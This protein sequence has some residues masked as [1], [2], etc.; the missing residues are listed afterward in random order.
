MTGD[1]LYIILYGGGWE[2]V[3]DRIG[4]IES[5]GCGAFLCFCKDHKL[6][7]HFG[8]SFSAD[9]S[10]LLESLDWPVFNHTGHTRDSWT[11][12]DGSLLSKQSLFRARRMLWVCDRLL[13]WQNVRKGEILAVQSQSFRFRVN[14][15]DL[16]NILRGG[17][18][19]S[20]WN[21]YAVWV[22]LH[23]WTISS[24]RVRYIP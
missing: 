1:E 4:S 22:S 6:F 20:L 16:T 23:L 13:A 7:Q 15:G 3:I 10:V 21:R 11:S 18:T 8:E 12:W 14:N 9:G 19:D 5:V 17:S 24:Y 2:F